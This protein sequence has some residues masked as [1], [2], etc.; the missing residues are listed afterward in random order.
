MRGS[1]SRLS[2]GLTRSPR[3]VGLQRGRH[4]GRQAEFLIPGG[5]P[6]VANVQPS[7][8]TGELDLSQTAFWAQPPA[9]RHAAYARLRA[10]SPPPFLDAGESPF[11]TVERDRKSTRLN[12]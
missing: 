1:G 7:P 3:V 8:L 5:R 9:W 2:R 11:G 10:M 12:S 4:H 6:S